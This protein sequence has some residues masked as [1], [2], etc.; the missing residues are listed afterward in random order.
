MDKIFR[1]VIEKFVK[2]ISQQTKIDEYSKKNL[3]NTNFLILLAVNKFDLSD[4]A[5]NN[6]VSKSE[7]SKLN[8]NR[9]YQIFVELPE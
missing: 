4:I 3:L 1:K 9:S 2:K 5:I 8:T 6:N 7:L